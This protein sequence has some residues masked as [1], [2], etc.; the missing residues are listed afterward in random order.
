MARKPRG[1]KSRHPKG[2]DLLWLETY[3]IVF[4]QNRRPTLAQVE[5]ALA[6]A[7]ARL[8]LRKP[9]GRRR[10]PVRV[11][12]GPIARKITPRSR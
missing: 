12:A 2:D 9:G 11:A 7:D 4:P 1:G 10:R 5:H 6:E 8:Q 3:F